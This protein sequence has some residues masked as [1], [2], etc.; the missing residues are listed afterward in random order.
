MTKYRVSMQISPDYTGRITESG[1]A[2]GRLGLGADTVSTEYLEGLLRE[3]NPHAKR[4]RVKVDGNV[5]NIS[6]KSRLLRQMEG[7]VTKP[8]EERG[9]ALRTKVGS[10]NIGPLL[11]DD[12]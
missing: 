3:S 4:I 10:D 11:G 1:P 5:L 9:Y 6:C 8:L 7:I 2:R 12:K